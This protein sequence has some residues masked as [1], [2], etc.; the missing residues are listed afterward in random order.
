MKK[1]RLLILS[2]DSTLYAEVIKR[3]DFTDLELNA[4]DSIDAAKKRIEHCNIILGE[5]TRIAPILKG[6]KRLQ[7]VQSA[8]AGVEALLGPGKRT[9]YVLTGVKDVFGPLMSE[10]VFAYILALERHIFEVYENQKERVWKKI[11]YKSLQGKLIGIC[12]LGSIGRHIAQ[13]AKHF[14]M[15]VWGFKRSY[16]EVPEVDRVF[17][18]RDFTAF[19]SNPD[20]I[21]L[22]LP[23]TP[24]TLHLI[25]YDA[26][27]AM[28][29]SAILISIGRGNVVSE[30]SLARALEAK[31]IRG[32][33]LD[34][35][36]EEPLLEASPLWALPN[37]LI[38][39]HNS[40]FS[41]PKNVVKIFAE[42]YR[43]FVKKKPLKHS[44]DFSRGY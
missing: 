7:W 14:E 27:N 6:A 32:A 35:F 12:G 20:Y 39:P 23:S 38:T 36:E 22:T 30:S 42:N 9:D 26:F 21:V 40:G 2:R 33:V 18:A 10:Y 25:D 4:C 41:F 8:F 5:P 37:V 28:K 15:K 11:P 44:V 3:L 34:V 43:R 1:N 31:L 29:R 19:L 17:T 16:E 24:E 13:T